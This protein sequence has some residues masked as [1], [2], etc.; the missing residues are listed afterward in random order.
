MT[1][2]A[3]V[4][5]LTTRAFTP[6][7][8]CQA[9]LPGD[10]DGAYAGGALGGLLMAA[11]AIYPIV[12]WWKASCAKALSS[13]AGQAGPT[14]RNFMMLSLSLWAYGAAITRF[15]L[16]S[17]KKYGAY[18]AI[19]A[20]GIAGG[21]CFMAF[22]V[23]IP[24]IHYAI[25]VAN[26]DIKNTKT[27]WVTPLLVITWTCHMLCGTTL[28]FGNVHLYTI[29]APTGVADPPAVCE[30][31]VTEA[32]KAMFTFVGL[33]DLVGFGAAVFA[34]IACLWPTKG[35]ALA[36]TA[37]VES[38][39][40]DVPKRKLPCGTPEWSLLGFSLVVAGRVLYT[41]AMGFE[42][43]FDAPSKSD[44]QGAD[45]IPGLI[46][47]LGCLPLLVSSCLVLKDKAKRTVGTQKTAFT[48]SFGIWAFGAVLALL[49]DADYCPKC[50]KTDT[51]KATRD[52]FIV[53][54]V[55]MLGTSVVA[56]FPTLS[57]T[58]A[59]LM[60]MKAEG[61]KAP[62]AS[63]DACKGMWHL[64]LVAWACITFQFGVF[65]GGGSAVIGASINGKS[66]ELDAAG[67][68]GGMSLL[69]AFAHL[70][71]GAMFGVA[72]SDAATPK[73][74]APSDAPRPE[75]RF[76]PATGK[77][78]TKRN[79][80]SHFVAPAIGSPGAP[81]PVGAGAGAGAGAAPKHVS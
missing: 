41:S 25:K 36:T 33:V 35:G 56:A 77:P 23:S 75:A 62:V 32:R 58:K 65:A 27:K 80:N 74:Q 55:I 28:G 29:V 38:G 45:A 30:G 14:W 52:M 24:A 17:Q 12:R 31:E 66:A 22:F 72:P 6:S 3:G 19:A 5:D 46:F 69:V 51:L 42:Q 78:I 73:L 21:A 10:K 81:A 49:F 79:S 15:A 59:R 13:Q 16:M 67:F 34:V 47:L 54:C 4:F 71:Y 48:L 70:Y 2:V 68:F 63:T 7:A 43:T 61:V 53:L 76:D 64:F 18:A 8:S 50:G 44:E 57:A 11:L 1:G 40:G 26:A 60:K 20:S 39:E 9:N 37:D